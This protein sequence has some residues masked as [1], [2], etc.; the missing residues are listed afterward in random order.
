MS[1]T[2][3]DPTALLSRSLDAL[4]L[5]QRGTANNVA[6]VDT[7]GFKTAEVR[8][9]NVLQ[10]ALRQDTGG[11]QLAMA[12]TD[13]QHMLLGGAE[14]SLRPEVVQQ[15]AMSLRNDENNVDI[16]QQMALLAETNLR[17]SAVSESLSRR[18]AMQRMIASDGR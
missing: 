2:R 18:F 4:A 17:F 12:R 5:R 1:D 11:V 7:P 10:R 9:E 6:N 13:S 8:F 15:D 3:I 16:E 14:A